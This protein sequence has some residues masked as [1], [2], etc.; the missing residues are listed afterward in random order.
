V[1]TATQIETEIHSAFVSFTEPH[2]FA[3]VILHIHSVELGNYLMTRI[4]SLFGIAVISA[5]AL[6]GQAQG[7]QAFNLNL[8]TGAA[9]P[10]GVKSQGAYS[11][12]AGLSTTKTVDFNSGSAPTTGFAKYSFQSANGS[13]SVRSDV[14]SPSGSKG[15]VNNG[16]Y[17][18]VFAGNNVTIDLA[19]KV[20]YFGINWGAMSGGNTF[21]FY[22]GT[23]LIKSY[24]TETV[25]PMALIHAQQHGGEG[26]GYAHFTA[27]NTSEMFDRIVISQVGGG[28]F[29]SDNH[30]FNISDP[31]KSVPEPGI[32]LGLAAIGGSV[33]AKRKRG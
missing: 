5:L 31:T 23:S 7:A 17:L 29:E 4:Q 26:N 10:T 27:S 15:E 32:M 19:D 22:N 24:S 13:S 28:G 6:V 30:S 11:E 2:S 21:S 9:S 20:K 16:N 8:T 3:A 25:A 1:K 33:W 18:A 12:F 14:W